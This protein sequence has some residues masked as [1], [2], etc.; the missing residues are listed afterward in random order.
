M[1][2]N[3][4]VALANNFVQNT[5][6]IDNLGLF[7]AVFQVVYVCSVLAYIEAFEASQRPQTPQ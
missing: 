3:K 5:S 6:K 4:C 7:W 1:M 2:T